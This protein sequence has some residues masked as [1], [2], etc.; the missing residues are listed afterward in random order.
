MHDDQE[1]HT[2]FFFKV[3]TALISFLEKK[4]NKNIL[5]PLTLLFLLS[6]EETESL[7]LAP[8]SLSL[9]NSVTWLLTQQRVFFHSE[10]NLCEKHKS[11]ALGRKKRRRKTQKQQ[12]L[13]QFLQGYIILFVHGWSCNFQRKAWKLRTNEP[14]TL[15]WQ[16]TMAHGWTP[17]AHHT[18]TSV[19]SH[20]KKT[21]TF[22]G[23]MVSEIFTQFQTIWWIALTPL[24]NSLTQREQRPYIGV[25]PRESI[26][27]HECPLFSSRLFS[28]AFWTSQWITMKLSLFFLWGADSRPPF[29]DFK[30]FVRL[31]WGDFWVKEYVLILLEFFMLRKGLVKRS[32]Q[33]P[34]DSFAKRGLLFIK[35][36]SLASLP[37]AYLTLRR[38]ITKK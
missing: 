27:T 11:G 38:L 6:A 36:N 23:H 3:L 9:S 22:G 31:V 1:L 25:S 10:R 8:L 21:R 14:S 29:G 20:I 18:E 15:M 4:R 19:S 37:W 12:V 28:L 2:F 7:W 13:V 30:W 32:N 26:C 16:A 33:G 34:H 35:L 24:L 17:A 5:G